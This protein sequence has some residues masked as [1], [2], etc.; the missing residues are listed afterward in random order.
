M[1]APH[2]WL[3][4]VQ[5]DL[6][7]I[8]DVSGDSSLRWGDLPWWVAF[9]RGNPRHAC[10]LFVSMIEKPENNFVSAW[11]LPA[12]YSAVAASFSCCHC[13]KIF[14]SKQSLAVH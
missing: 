11:S 5:D 9:V 7:W 10:K 3:N 8:C 14:R 4:I 1:Q 13:A 2:A 6:N 12:S